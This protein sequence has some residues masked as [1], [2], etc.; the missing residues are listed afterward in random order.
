MK[1]AESLPHVVVFPFP[2]Q[3]HINPALQFAQLL[4]SSLSLCRVTFIN[5]SHNIDK[6]RA[7]HLDLGCHIRLQALADNGQHGH[8]PD[9]F[10]S[11]EQMGGLLESL[12][13]KLLQ[14]HTQKE[15]SIYEH[16]GME[17]CASACRP[18][19]GELLKGCTHNHK[20]SYEVCDEEVAW[21]PPICIISDT[22]LSWVQDIA[23]KFSLPRFILYT[24][25]PAT[26]VLMLSLPDML[27]QGRLP[28]DSALDEAH[29]H[30][31]DL[32]GL[33]H[34]LTLADVPSHL[35]LPPTAFMFNYFIRHS[36]RIPNAAAVLVNTFD[37]LQ[38]SAVQAARALL[39]ASPTMW[40]NSLHRHQLPR[41]IPI[42]P[43]LP[44][45][46]FCGSRASASRAS[47]AEDD[48]CLQ[49]LQRQEPASVMYVSFGSM[50]ELSRE[51][52]HELAWGLEASGMPFLWVVRG[53]GACFLPSGFIVGMDFKAGE[54]VELATGTAPCD[55]SQ[56]QGDLNATPSA[57]GSSAFGTSDADHITVV[58]SAARMKETKKG[59]VVSWAPQLDVLSHPSV[60]LFLS[61]CGWNSTLEAISAGIPVLGWPL[62]AEQKMNC[63]FLVDELKVAME[64]SKE[65]GGLVGKEE[66]ERVIREALEMERGHLMR[67]HISEWKGLARNAVTD[68]GRSQENVKAFGAL[69]ASL[70][71]SINQ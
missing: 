20:G 11:I 65:E 51:Q 4:A 31:L 61:H 9:V 64:F 67:K 36:K 28:C 49:W 25:S 21:P 58:G 19:Y 62:F 53:D 47:G 10:E 59:L 57:F 17:E 15:K 1:H 29:K 13:V 69:V 45:S 52:V 22:F 35:L 50:G 40:E 34:T 23:D 30:S 14:T 68:G 16:K 55:D 43:L 56:V 8:G 42:G 24:P 38:G 3:G 7:A 66:V 70:H 37:E 41:V 12:L 46:I 5:T 18:G 71:A 32:P 63:R 26:L 2:A 33:T 39:D 54:G 60:A 44:S 48:I 6:L 27:L